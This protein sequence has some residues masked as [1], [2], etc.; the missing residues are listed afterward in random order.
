MRD[1]GQAVPIVLQIWFWLTPIVYPVSIIPEAYR[2]WFRLNPVYPLVDAYHR[3]L[4][5]GQA[6]D[7]ASVVQI[8]GFALGLLLVALF[9]FRRAAEEMV[10]V[11]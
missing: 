8:A 10:D 6:P 1:V 11:L 7:L 3:V 4:V 9:V 5:Y 2:P